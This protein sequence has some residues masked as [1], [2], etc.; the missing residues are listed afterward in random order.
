MH[1]P[2]VPI[3][4]TSVGIIHGDAHPSNTMV[5]SLG[6]DSWQMSVLDLDHAHRAWYIM[7][8]GTEVYFANMMMWIQ[9]VEDRET[10]L[11][12]FEDWIMDSYG[13]DIT[14][15]ELQ[16]GC[17]VRQ[18]ILGPMLKIDLQILP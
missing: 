3:T 6:N 1:K 14:H 13:W 18:S 2:D 17:Q 10:K 16:Q 11:A 7:D 8:L 12:Q 15:Y 4:D 9:Q 5:K